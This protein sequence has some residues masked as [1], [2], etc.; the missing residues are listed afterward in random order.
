MAV[1]STSEVCLASSS[2]G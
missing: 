2:K 1:N